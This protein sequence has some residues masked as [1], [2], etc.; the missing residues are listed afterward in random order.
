LSALSSRRGALA[1]LLALLIGLATLL[2]GCS[3]M[4]AQ[5]PSTPMQPVNAVRAGDDARL[6]LRGYDVVA[7][8]TQSQA[9]P[10]IAQH[11]AEF[12]GVTYF[13]ANAQHLAQFQREPARYQPAYHGYD[14]MRMVFALP[15]AADPTVWRIV[16]G[17]T[18]LFADGASKAAFELDLAANIAL[19]DKYWNSEVAGSNSTWQSLR[20]RVDRVPHYRSRDELAGEVAA[21]KGKA[22]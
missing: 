8:V 21:A 6:M 13:F 16:D 4:V 19:A 18:F 5:N 20:R 1:L 9:V 11:R 17:R 12:E 22:G 14:A 10:G 2:A 7:Y 15:E 3:A